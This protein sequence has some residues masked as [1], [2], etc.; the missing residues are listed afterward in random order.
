MTAIN[1]TSKSQPALLSQGLR[2]VAGIVVDRIRQFARAAKHR[3]DAATLAGLDDRMLADIGLTRGDLRDAFSEPP[4]RD[5]TAVLVDRAG[6]R[7][8][9]RYR[10]GIAAA[11]QVTAPSIVPA[12]DSGSR[13][14]G[15]AARNV[16]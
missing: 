9:Y 5:P 12:V 6:E 8:A 14:P 13:V 1:Q 16:F 15:L 11:R 4:W 7:R 2:V 3:H 10:A